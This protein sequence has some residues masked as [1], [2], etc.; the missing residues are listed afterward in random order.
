MLDSSETAVTDRSLEIWLASPQAATHFRLNALSPGEAERYAA[1]RSA[2]R[3]LDFVVGRALHQQALRDM[4]G[5]PARSSLTH[6][7]G[8]AALARIGVPVQL[9]IDLERHTPR[10]VLSL[11]RF[12]Y[13]AREAAALETLSEA[14]RIHTFYTLWTLKEA[15]A[16]ALQLP[17]LEALKQCIF[18]RE[19]STLYGELP[20]N[21]P[22]RAYLFAPRKD[23]SLAIALV[24][25]ATTPILRL[26]EWPPLS[27]VNWPE[28]FEIRHQGSAPSDRGA[29]IRGDQ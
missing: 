2:A 28:P 18:L 29:R 19:G 6:S 5:R 7:G 25:S 1:I 4:A 22:W 17:L 21:L 3:R 8:H 10:N 15:F 11:A 26:Y 9:G 27:T 20:T 13:A 14:D 12:A 16:K 23:L 24:G